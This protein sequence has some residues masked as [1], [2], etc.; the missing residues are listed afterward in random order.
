MQTEHAF[1]RLLAE[2]NVF[3][4]QINYFKNSTVN[5]IGDSIS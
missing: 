5:K 1:R 3:I 4:T 2:K